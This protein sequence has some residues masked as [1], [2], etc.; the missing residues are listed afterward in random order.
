MRLS[1]LDFRLSIFDRPVAGDSD[2]ADTDL[3][4]F[5]FVFPPLCFSFCFFLCVVSDSRIEGFIGWEDFS[6]GLEVFETHGGRSSTS[7]G[8]WCIGLFSLGKPSLR[9][10]A[11]F[12]PR[13]TRRNNLS[14]D[15]FVGFLLSGLVCAPDS[16]PLR[17]LFCPDGGSW[18]PFRSVSCWSRFWF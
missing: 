9:S 18:S 2:S 7:W 17:S 6:F 16:L 1:S 10:S 13:S 4:D 3:F 5:S 11:F 12:R 14:P 8:R 15:I